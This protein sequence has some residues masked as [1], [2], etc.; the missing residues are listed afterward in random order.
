MVKLKQSIMGVISIDLHH[1]YKKHLKWEIPIH[2]ENIESKWFPNCWC[3]GGY[4]LHCQNT[5]HVY[6]NKLH[7]IKQNSFLFLVSL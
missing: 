1:I 4:I 5:V 7:G 2:F 3:C 6:L